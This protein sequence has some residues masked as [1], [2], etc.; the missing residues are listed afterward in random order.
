MVALLLAGGAFAA[1]HWVR[2]QYFVGVYGDQVAVFRGL[3]QD[4]GPINLA[5]LDH[6]TGV[7]L[8]S[9]PP[10]DQDSVKSGLVVDSRSQAAEKVEALRQAA[11]GTLAASPPAGSATRAPSPGASGSPPS[12][13]PSASR[14]LAVVGAPPTAS[15]AVPAQPTQAPVYIQ[16][17]SPSGAGACGGS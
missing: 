3:P 5:S 11:C 6:T 7:L 2:E 13:T 17:S 12:S 15:G 1:W 16:P 14:Q 10:A 8:Q 9:L 4:L